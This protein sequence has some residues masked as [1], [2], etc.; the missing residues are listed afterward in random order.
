MCS[1]ASRRVAGGT[2]LRYSATRADSC[3]LRAANNLG[4]MSFSASADFCDRNPQEKLMSITPPF[5][6]KARIMSSVMLRPAFEIA[7]HEEWD[8]KTGAVLT[9]R[10]SQNVLSA[11]CEISTIMPRRFISRT[12]SLPKSVRPLWCA[13]LVSLISPEES[14]HSLVLDQVNVMYL[15]PRR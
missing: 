10:A 1:T 3:A 6:A 4:M 2:D 8:A 15:T 5:L 13:I 9:S 7:R 11:T 14:A 12:T